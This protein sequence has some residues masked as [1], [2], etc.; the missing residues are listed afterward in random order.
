MEGFKNNKNKN[1]EGVLY[2]G[3]AVAEPPFNLSAR[4]LLSIGSLHSVTL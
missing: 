4:F 3:S 1:S 2:G